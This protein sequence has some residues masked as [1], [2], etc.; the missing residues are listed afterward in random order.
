MYDI[1]EV[2]DGKVY[3]INTDVNTHI[4]C[5]SKKCRNVDGQVEKNE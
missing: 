5:P 3:S 1:W 4:S 2:Q